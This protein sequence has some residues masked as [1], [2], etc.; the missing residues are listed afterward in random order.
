[1]NKNGKPVEVEL[2]RGAILPSEL[3]H[4]LSMAG[5]DATCTLITLSWADDYKSSVTDI[6]DVEPIEDAEE[7]KSVVAKF[8]YGDESNLTISL[9]QYYRNTLEAFGDKARERQSAISQYWAGLPERSLLTYLTANWL[10]SLPMVLTGG[11]VTF[12][13]AGFIFHSRRHAMELWT[14]RFSFLLIVLCIY[15]FI[16]STHAIRAFS[17]LVVLARR[18]HSNVWTVVAGIT[19]IAGLCLSVAAYFFPRQ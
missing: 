4:I 17:R 6:R 1:L 7:V 11:A 15:L 9:R 16:R 10:R 12:F 13:L 3:A 2:K 14:L 8:R 19:A 18:P 5:P